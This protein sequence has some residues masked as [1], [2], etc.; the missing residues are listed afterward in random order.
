MTPMQPQSTAKVFL[1][2]SFITALLLLSLVVW[3][4]TGYLFRTETSNAGA[5]AVGYAYDLVLLLLS[6]PFFLVIWFVLLIRLLRE[7]RS[8]HLSPEQQK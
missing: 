1:I 4:Y 7:R 5:N 8:G 6:T 2:V 3:F